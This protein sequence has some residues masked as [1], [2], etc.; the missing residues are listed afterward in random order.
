MET[1]S[2][3]E[4]RLA[5]TERQLARQQR[6]FGAVLA[7]LGI[8]VL[9]SAQRPTKPPILSVSGLEVLDDS[10]RT[11]ARL[12]Y[13]S[14]GG[15][16]ELMGAG[17][18]PA[19]SATAMNN[20]GLLTIHDGKG[21]VATRIFHGPFGSQLIMRRASGEPTVTL[22]ATRMGGTVTVHDRVGKPLGSL[23]ADR[24]GRGEIEILD[25]E[26]KNNKGIKF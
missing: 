22:A 15:R 3:L 24:R 9:L 2:K 16:M 1:L 14:A 21:E 5:R 6:L 11:A 19:I 23:R 13:S 4:E 26:A 25:P 8:G 10:G 12:T 17:N 7:V 18:K 20:G